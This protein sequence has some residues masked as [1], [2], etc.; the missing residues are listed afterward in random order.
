MCFPPHSPQ[1]V[2]GITPNSHQTRDWG[3]GSQGQRHSALTLFL[4]HSAAAELRNAGQEVP[5]MGSFLLASIDHMCI[6]KLLILG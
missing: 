1:D 5:S 3:N 4:K 2:P 6:H